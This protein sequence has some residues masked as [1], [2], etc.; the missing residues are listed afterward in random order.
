MTAN[1]Y[2]FNVSFAH[3]NPSYI[4]ELQFKFVNNIDGKM[5]SP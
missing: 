2:P 4:Q 1:L 5:A 3:V